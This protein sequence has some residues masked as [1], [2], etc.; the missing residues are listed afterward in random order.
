VVA[1][2]LRQSAADRESALR[3]EFSAYLRLV[4]TVGSV[5]GS[6]S[7]AAQS[8]WSD[9]STDGPDKVSATRARVV[10]PL[11]ELLSQLRRFPTGAPEVTAL[12]AE[13]VAA[14]SAAL[15]SYAVLLRTG[16]SPRAAD[17]AAFRLRQ[18]EEARHLRAW[19]EM[20]VDLARRLTRATG[21]GPT[22]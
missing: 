11:A 15:R 14:V 8:I 1:G 9:P 5:L 21:Q 16:G 20:R 18:A 7:S 19:R 3:T 13:L 2:S 22:G 10:A 12:H 4:P 6:T 17:V